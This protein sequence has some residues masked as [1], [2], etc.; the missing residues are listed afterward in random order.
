MCNWGLVRRLNTLSNLGYLDDIKIEKRLANL[1][2]R[3]IRPRQDKPMLTEGLDRKTAKPENCFHPFLLRRHGEIPVA[4]L[5]LFAIGSQDVNE[6][7]PFECGRHC[8]FEYQRNDQ[9]LKMDG[10]L[11]R[12]DFF[13]D[14]KNR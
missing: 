2:S 6:D 10:K 3:V 1:G 8:F 9:R 11:R 4:N 5:L 12:P 7:A 13:D 14:F